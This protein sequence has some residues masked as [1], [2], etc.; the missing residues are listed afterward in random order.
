MRLLCKIVILMK[1]RIAFGFAM[2]ALLYLALKSASV[3]S[4]AEVETYNTVNMLQISSGPI[5]IT[6]DD[7][8]TDYG[9]EGTGN[10]TDPFI[11]ENLSINTASDYGIYVTATTKH[12]RYTKTC[13]RPLVQSQNAHLNK[14]N[15][16]LLL[17]P[18]S[19]RHASMLPA[20]E[21]L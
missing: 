18:T 13:L 17:S 3:S 9:F 21:G 16:A 6:H 8:F 15:H 7:N 19:C 2:I 11:I 10:E 14:H 1:K 4:Y 12:Y 5:R 20:F